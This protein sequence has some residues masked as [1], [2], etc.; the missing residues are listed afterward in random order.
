MSMKKASG[1]RQY[2]TNR[3]KYLAQRFLDLRLQGRVI[4]VRSDSAICARYLCGIALISLIYAIS[5]VFFS[6]PSGAVSISP[7]IISGE[8]SFI[9]YEKGESVTAGF[10]YSD[11]YFSR[12]GKEKNEHLR[13]YALDLAVTV[14]G[15]DRGTYNSGFTMDLLGKSGFSMNDTVCVDMEEIPTEDTI[16]TVISHKKTAYGEVIAVAVRGGS[17]GLEW[18]NTFDVGAS[19]D[20]KGLSAAAHKVT[21]RIREYEKKYGLNG[22]KLFITGY[23]RGGSVSDLAGKYINEGIGE[24]G[25]TADD[26]YVYTFEAP[27]ASCTGNSYEN[28]HNVVN[29]NDPVPLF[30]SENWG[31]YNAGV[32]ESLVAEDIDVRYKQLEITLSGISSVDKYTSFFNT[33]TFRNEK[34]Y[35]NPVSLRV[36]EKRIVGWITGAVDRA[37]YAAHSEGVRS[38]VKLFYSADS[39]DRAAMIKF[40]SDAYTGF[41][42]G[43]IKNLYDLISMFGNGASAEEA[44]NR[45]FSIMEYALDSTDHSSIDDDKFMLL[46]SALPDVSYLVAVLLIADYRETKVFEYTCTFVENAAAMI[47]QH[48]TEK[49]LALAEIE[50]D[51]FYPISVSDAEITIDEATAD[52]LAVKVNGVLL[53]AG[54]DYSVFY[55]DSR[56][57]TVEPYKSGEYTAVVSGVGSFSGVAEKKFTAVFPHYHKWEFEKRGNEIAVKCMADECGYGTGKE[58]TVSLSAENKTYD[59]RPAKV[60]I[61]KSSG[62]PEEIATGNTGFVNENNEP[63]VYAPEMPGKYKAVADVCEKENEKN[64][65]AAECIFTIEAISLD[66]KNTLIEM[67][68]NSADVISVMFGDKLLKEGKDYTIRYYDKDGNVIAEPENAGTYAVSVIGENIYSGECRKDFTIN[69]HIIIVVASAIIAV[70]I[71]VF[72]IIIIS[73]KKSRKY[74]SNL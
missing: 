8:F 59:G 55:H 26:L 30:F 64:H 41:K 68:E 38:L 23:S 51:Y 13:T 10:F 50:D 43:N 9:S 14:F 65:A 63:S 7:K 54:S 62:F 15:S 21:D 2:L 20:A 71:I 44:G 16:G 1:L 4:S 39:D 73:G 67:K 40:V 53:N 70:A 57:F 25:I 72:A 58:Y 56:G 29:I 5:A 18:V 11:D 3:R 19:G 33:K 49:A 32:K 42:V 46:K 37:V 22:A 27:A 45:L 48:Y 74:K 66:D 35:A 60:S 31:L 28:I 6:L 61:T 12:S 24:Y 52:V 34:T 69:D 36:A 47:L 17:Y